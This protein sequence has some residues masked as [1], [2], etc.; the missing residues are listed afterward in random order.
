MTHRSATGWST[1]G[2][3]APVYPSLK[4]RRPWFDCGGRAGPVDAPVPPPP[5]E[6]RTYPVFGPRLPSHQRTPT[7]PVPTTMHRAAGAPLVGEKRALAAGA[8]TPGGRAGRPA[9][10]T[11]GSAAAEAAPGGS[12]FPPPSAGSSTGVAGRT[13]SPSLAP[14]SQRSPSRAASSRTKTSTQSLTLWW[15]PS[16]TASCRTAASCK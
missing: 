6:D 2:T 16:R 7:Q 8:A 5:L 12:S 15:S 3:C 11:G 9:A 10:A 14:A 4:F 13:L 1:N